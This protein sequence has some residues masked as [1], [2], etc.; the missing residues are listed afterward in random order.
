MMQKDT[1]VLKQSPKNVK[2][3]ELLPDAIESSSCSLSINI[4]KCLGTNSTDHD[5]LESVECSRVCTP[6]SLASPSTPVCK[7]SHCRCHSEIVG[8]LWTFR[9]C[10]SPPEGSTSRFRIRV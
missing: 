5:R 3:N 2:L 4:L 10:F 7:S 8:G 9:R 1:A 6:E